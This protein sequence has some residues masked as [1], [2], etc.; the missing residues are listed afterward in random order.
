MKRRRKKQI[1][2][3]FRMKHHVIQLPEQYNLTIWRN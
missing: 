1:Q 2:L 3:R